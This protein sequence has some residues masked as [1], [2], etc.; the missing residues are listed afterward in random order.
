[1]DGRPFAYRP[2]QPLARP[3]QQ[4]PDQSGEQYSSRI[5]DQPAGNPG[6]WDDNRD[7]LLEAFH[8]RRAQHQ[9]NMA[10][11]LQTSFQPGFG[12]TGMQLAP[13]SMPMR[14]HTS[15]GYYPALNRMPP[16]NESYWMVSNHGA[17]LSSPMTYGNLQTR[18]QQPSGQV[19][20]YLQLL[21]YPHQ[22]NNIS[23]P[24]TNNIQHPLIH[25]SQTSQSMLP[26]FPPG[27][28]PPTT[29]PTTQQQPQP[30]QS[31]LSS[32]QNQ[33]QETLPS[34]KSG[35]AVV[36][37]PQYLQVYPTTFS[38]PQFNHHLPNNDNGAAGQPVRPDSRAGSRVSP[39][40][41]R[42]S[43]SGRRRAY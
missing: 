21:T 7:S 10:H 39:R 11:Q 40:Q 22:H 42:S 23:E 2:W 36:Q 4:S 6:E 37:T 24:T 41:A 32:H 5:P 30:S 35:Q 31:L 13:G 25:S 26:T 16:A 29:S 1:M 9:M 17:S 8:R 33:Q 15:Q 14:Y 19:P 20:D 34:T 28:N 27:P 12:L 3:A 18:P 38:T 43:W